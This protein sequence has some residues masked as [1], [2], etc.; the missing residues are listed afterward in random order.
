MSFS[1]NVRHLS[2]PSVTRIQHVRKR[3]HFDPMK[4]ACCVCMFEMVY[5]PMSDSVSKSSYLYNGAKIT[6]T[7]PKCR[8]CQLSCS[9][10]ANCSICRPSHFKAKFCLSIQKKISHCCSNNYRCNHSCRVGG[11]LRWGGYLSRFFYFSGLSLQCFD[12]VG[13]AA[14]RASGL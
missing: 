8:C 9:L 13:W 3:I 12:A 10:V 2:N 5:L 11:D 1:R 7:P 14:G 6:K 4:S